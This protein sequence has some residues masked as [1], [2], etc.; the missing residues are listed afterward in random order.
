MTYNKLTDQ[1]KERVFAED[2][3]EWE[4]KDSYGFQNRYY[5]KYKNKEFH[6]LTDFNHA[7]L[8]VE[9]LGLLWNCF[10]DGTTYYFSFC[11]TSGE[12]MDDAFSD[13]SLNEAIVEA[14]IKIVRP[15]LFEGE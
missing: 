15:D 11:D 10:F 4:I 2:V 14:C 7:M 5:Y 1:E 13:I 8:G 9:K 3:L 6:P 12:Y